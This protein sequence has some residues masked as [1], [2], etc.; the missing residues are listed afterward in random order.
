MLINE[1]S[2]L[3]NVSKK[4]HL[5]EYDDDLRSIAVFSSSI[6]NAICAEYLIVIQA[7]PT[8]RMYLNDCA[9]LLVFWRISAHV[10]FHMRMKRE[11]SSH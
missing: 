11:T 6:P 2:S 8:L 9:S 7:I 1:L 10:V 5:V 4:M 3:F